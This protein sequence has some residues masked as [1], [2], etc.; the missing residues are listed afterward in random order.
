MH[1]DA[2]VKLHFSPRSFFLFI[3]HFPS[4]SLSPF[5]CFTLFG[6]Y[7]HP[8]PPF[9]TG[10]ELFIIIYT[11]KLHLER[12]GVPDVPLALLLLLGES[13]PDD[14]LL[15]LALLDLLVYRALGDPHQH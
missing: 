10:R 9:P 15:A 3:S 11:L 4:V 14:H 7:L 6:R 12:G 1:F 2:A 5:I 8:P 13:G